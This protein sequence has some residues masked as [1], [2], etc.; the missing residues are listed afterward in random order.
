VLSTACVGASCT[1]RLL[2]M[3]K[4]KKRRRL[5][6][7]VRALFARFGSEGGKIGGKARWEGTT[8]EERSEI[9]RKAANARWNK[10]KSE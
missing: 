1:A 6:K 4:A 3:R 7:G 9:A 8:P 2:L 5:P 10:T